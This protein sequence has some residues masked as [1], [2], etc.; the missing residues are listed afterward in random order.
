M[1]LPVRTP[2]DDLHPE[3]LTL[4]DVSY[5]AVEK[6]TCDYFKK[7]LQDTTTIQRRK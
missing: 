1:C 5:I 7:H 2:D 3:R 4:D 6:C